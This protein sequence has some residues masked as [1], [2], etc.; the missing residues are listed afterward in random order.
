MPTC[1]GCHRGVDYDELPVHLQICDHVRNSE[2]VPNTVLEG[3]E[4]QIVDL[5]DRLESRIDDH[6]REVLEQLAR[7]ETSLQSYG[8]TGH[9]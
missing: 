9:E 8:M 5:E 1:P 6:D 2:G 7:L 3:V 4:R